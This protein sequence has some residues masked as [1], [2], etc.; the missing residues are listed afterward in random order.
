MKDLAFIAGCHVA[1]LSR[2]VSLILLI[3]STQVNSY[4]TS[5]TNESNSGSSL[6]NIN[7]KS[8]VLDYLILMYDIINILDFNDN[9]LNLEHD[10]QNR[11]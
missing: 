11:E 1:L 6:T 5:F 9:V 7:N 8:D 3:I 10:D 4:P 2:L